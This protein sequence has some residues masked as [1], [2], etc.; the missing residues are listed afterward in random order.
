MV[1]TSRFN[2][3]LLCLLPIFSLTDPGN[4]RLH[5]W[6][7]YRYQYSGLTKSTKVLG[8]SGG[9]WWSPPWWS[10][11]WSSVMSYQTCIPRSIRRGEI[12]HTSMRVLQRSNVV[13]LDNV[14]ALAAALKRAVPR[15]LSIISYLQRSQ[16]L[17]EY[18]RTVNQLTW[19]ESTG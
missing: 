17:T 14:A 7:I 4:S 11:W 13:Q 9:A 12:R 3:S 5:A 15:H 2:P 19:W 18:R 6:G 16:N 8:S 1:G 10:P